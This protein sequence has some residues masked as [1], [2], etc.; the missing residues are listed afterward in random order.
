MAKT[1]VK[2]IS[3][4]SIL[5]HGVAKPL[6]PQKVTYLHIIARELDC[7]LLKKLVKFRKPTL[8][9]INVLDLDQKTPFR[10]AVDTVVK[11]GRQGDPFIDYMI[12]LGAEPGI[13]DKFNKS[14]YISEV[15]K[16]KNPDIDN[17]RTLLNYY[18]PQIASLRG[19][20][21]KA[22]SKN[23]IRPDVDDSTDSDTY[24]EYDS[25]DDID[26]DSDLSKMIND[27]NENEDEVGGRPVSE[28]TKQK[29]QEILDIFMKETGRDE[30]TCRVL[31]SALKHKVLVDN[32]ALKG[33][34]NDDAKITAMHDIVTN[35][36]ELKAFLKKELPHVEETKKL[37]EDSIKAK[38]DKFG[39]PE[40]K[41]RSK[42]NSEGDKIMTKEA[43][44]TKKTVKGGYLVS[45]E[46]VFF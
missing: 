21:T 20:A 32:P 26:R 18:Q 45:E 27:E 10:Y 28:E 44:K 23:N 43:S 37:I 15:D 34:K 25:Q 24:D 7:D 9:E 17:I 1:S 35:K 19:G 12:E 29:L 22:K 39:G 11:Q 3:I 33:G 8:E 4:D 42:K 46:N 16:M 36:T 14:V 6:N 13:T 30:A 38:K 40:N 31:R 5:N 41:P 2:N